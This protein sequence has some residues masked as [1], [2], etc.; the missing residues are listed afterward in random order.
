MTFDGAASEC[1]EVLPTKFNLNFGF[2]VLVACSVGL[3]SCG[4][5]IPRSTLPAPEYE[6]PGVAP[7]PINAD[8][9]RQDPLP[10]QPTAPVEDAGGGSGNSD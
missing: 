2:H 10:G 5:D 7:W 8:A 4:G 9:G 6:R 3:V 1:A